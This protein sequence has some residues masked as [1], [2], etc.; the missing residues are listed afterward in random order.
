MNPTA[1]PWLLSSFALALWW[2]RG[3]RL[4]LR[5]LLAGSFGAGM[6]LIPF[7]ADALGVWLGRPS[8]DGWLLGGLGCLSLVTSFAYFRGPKTTHRHGV[9]A[10][11]AEVLE[12]IES[13]RREIGGPPVEGLV[14]PPIG[15]F[16]L[17]GASGLAQ[18]FVFVTNSVVF[19]LEPE[20]RRAILGHEV[21]HHT[22]GSLWLLAGL[23]ALAPAVALWIDP[24]VSEIAIFAL[25]IVLRFAFLCAVSRP[26]EYLCDALG[27]R[28]TSREAMARGLSRII[29]YNPLDHTSR[30]SRILHC[31]W[32]HPA[33]ERRLARL[34]QPARRGQLLRDCVVPALTVVGIVAVASWFPAYW[35]RGTLVACLVVSVL[36]ILA[37]KPNP[38]KA[39]QKAPAPGRG[40]F[41][42]WVFVSLGSIFGL[43]VAVSFEQFLLLAVFILGLL[44][45]ALGLPL[46]AILRGRAVRLRQRAGVLLAETPTEL[47]ELQ[48]AR[49]LAFRKDPVLLHLVA[50]A[51]FRV[52]DRAGAVEDHEMLQRRWPAFLLPRATLA[53][54]IQRD[55]PRRV[56]ELLSVVPPGNPT[57]ARLVAESQ[58]RLGDLGK[59][60]ESL[61]PAIDRAPL[62]TSVLAARASIA[63]AEGEVE[64]AHE[65]LEEA[66][67]LGAI[68]DAPL[69]IVS[70]R[71]AV[72]MGEPELAEQGIDKA[73]AILDGRPLEDMVVRPDLLEARAELETWRSGVSLNE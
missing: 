40:L 12:E 18:P 53:E 72:A 17:A 49:K 35:S 67:Q 61:Q 10:A 27:A 65:I 23:P 62:E 14:G 30:A 52:G 8:H 71:V 55:D 47:L 28:V 46:V 34:A 13:A 2:G 58:L 70:A 16:L 63:L 54:Q 50:M 5:T 11:S 36:F 25:T 48:E 51:K 22:T 4:G 32:T 64:E 31:F 56:I 9:R 39:L 15:M 19:C 20:E 45:S 7:L 43:I 33:T 37:K 66:A 42:G 3:A 38:W 26:I 68:G 6:M 59:A 41:Y 73:E 21:G 29:A 69:L 57:I 24:G 1:W 44:L 60:K